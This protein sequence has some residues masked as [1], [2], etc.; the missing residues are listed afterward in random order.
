MQMLLNSFDDLGNA[1]RRYTRWAA[2]GPAGNTFFGQA[3]GG[4]GKLDKGHHRREAGCL[5]PFP[6]DPASAQW[7]LE[8]TK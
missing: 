3:L 8:K 5:R 6:G 7:R 1:G 4:F 2:S